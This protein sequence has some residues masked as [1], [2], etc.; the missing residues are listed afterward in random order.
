MRSMVDRF[1]C[2]FLGLAALAVLAGQTLAQTT[3]NPTQS[4]GRKMS[5]VFFQDDQ[6][7]SLKWADLYLG[8]EITLGP[9]SEVKGFPKLDPETQSLVQMQASEEFLLLGVRDDQDGQFQSGWVLVDS[10]VFKEEHGDHFHWRYPREPSVRAKMLDQQQGNPAH[11]YCYDGVFYVANDKLD[12]CTRIDPRGITHTDTEASIVQRAALHQGGGGHITLA[13]VR[14]QFI[15]STWVD[16]QGDNMGRIDVCSIQ[17]K[18]N[19]SLM[20]TLKLPSGGLHGATAVQ[21]KVFFAP[22]DG[23][24]W[25]QIPQ[26]NNWR[27]EDLQLHHLSLGMEGDKP[28]RTGAFESFDRYVCFTTGSGAGAKLN[29]IDASQA[30]PVVQSLSVPMQ[31]GNKPAGLEL[32]KDRARNVWAFVFHDHAAG[33]DAANKLSIVQLDGNLDGV[34]GDAKVSK[35]LDVGQA[36]IE[37]HGGHHS[38]STSADA[39]WSVLSNSG[40]GTLSLLS[41]REMNIAKTVK[42]GGAPSKVLMVGG[43]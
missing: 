38:I 34:W 14:N 11:L 15:L 19:R 1:K 13:A 23:V 22:M 35:E 26:G 12:G 10:G 3:A 28:I 2:L 21:S 5:R 41:I 29:W 25:T 4:L 37:G 9:V 42:V 33:V 8:T 27:V 36:I 30:T 16:R 39:L 18:G 43:R 7:K 32:L 40:D 17:P 20:G 31:D 24:Y 6:S